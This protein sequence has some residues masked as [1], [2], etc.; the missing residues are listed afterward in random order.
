MNFVTR[1]VSAG[2]L[3]ACVTAFGSPAFASKLVQ[4]APCPSICKVINDSTSLPLTVRSFTFNAP[5]K[6]T[7]LVHFHGS[8]MCSGAAG[9]G[10]NFN[11]QIVNVPGANPNAVGPGGLKVFGRSDD[12]AGDM[13]FNLASNRVFKVDQGNNVFFFKIGQNAPGTG[14]NPG[15]LCFVY[16]ASFTVLLLP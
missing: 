10:F 7:A 5:N 15:T 1:L 14:L 6:G 3:L 2:I 16:N 12:S 13:P 8:M 11:T 9:F 4:Q